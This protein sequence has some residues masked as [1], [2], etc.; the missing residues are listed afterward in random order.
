MKDF[1]QFIDVIKE[2]N[3]LFDTLIPIEQKKLDLCS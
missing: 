3:E 1:S 2:F